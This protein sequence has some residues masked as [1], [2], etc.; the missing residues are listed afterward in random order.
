MNEI[1]LFLG[2]GCSAEGALASE[3]CR[4]SGSLLVLIVTAI[5]S[6]LTFALRSLFAWHASSKKVRQKRREAI[7]DMAVFVEFLNRDIQ[8]KFNAGV[9]PTLENTIDT[10]PEGFVFYVLATGDSTALKSIRS[11]KHTFEPSEIAYIDAYADL[12]EHFREYYEALASSAFAQLSRR[13]KKQ[14][15]RNL[16]DIGVE[17]RRARDDLIQS[18]PEIGDT[19]RA[20]PAILRDPP[21]SRAS[22]AHSNDGR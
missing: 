21:A 20:V 2:L 9:L 18:V 10:E 15:L 7:V 12:A 6:L 5:I 3:L 17:V 13:R 19:I 1:L 11:V 16:I 4:I 14:V 8:G 22:S